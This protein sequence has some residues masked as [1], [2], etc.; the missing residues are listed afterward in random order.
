MVPRARTYTHTE[1]HR[2]WENVFWNWSRVPSG[3]TECV[4]S[5][6]RFDCQI[7]TR[8]NGRKNFHIAMLSHNIVCCVFFFPLVVSVL[9]HTHTRL[10][11]FCCVYASLF[12]LFGSCCFR[13]FALSAGC[14]HLLLR[15][16]R[17]PCVLF[18]LFFVHFQQQQQQQSIP[19]I[20]YVYIY[21]YCD[22]TVAVEKTSIL[23]SKNR[24]SIAVVAA[25]VVI[26]NITVVCYSCICIFL[27][28]LLRSLGV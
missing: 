20:H 21:I 16:H 24:C 11:F 9:T 6:V 12:G 19:Y 1:R 3:L 25:A 2:E 7:R 13:W 26:T 17:T 15:V 18:F 10:C 22:V 14:F 5:F 27:Q 8:I 28:F 4:R 23:T